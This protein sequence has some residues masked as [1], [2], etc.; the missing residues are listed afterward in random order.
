MFLHNLV[1]DRRGRHYITEILSKVAFYNINQ[2]QP[3]DHA[4]T[5]FFFYIIIFI[6]RL[7]FVVVSVCI[8]WSYSGHNTNNEY[9][10]NQNHV[11]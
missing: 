2:P 1:K 9:N 4:S 6:E 11:L 7:T 5:S 10:P 3:R 8:V